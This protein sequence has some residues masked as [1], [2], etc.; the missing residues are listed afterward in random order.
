ML[1]PLLACNRCYI[2]TVLDYAAQ[3]V[4]NT[5]LTNFRSYYSTSGNAQEIIILS[6]RIKRIVHQVRYS[7]TVQIK[8][9]YNDS[10]EAMVQSIPSENL[11]DGRGRECEFMQ[12]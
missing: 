7:Q 6:D 9:T 3:M 5:D 10:A 1:L 12:L 4:R 11:H 2:N 8:T